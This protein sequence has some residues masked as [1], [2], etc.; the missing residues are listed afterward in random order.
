MAEHRQLVEHT[1]DPGGELPL[2]HEGDEVG[3][4]EQVPELVLDVAVVD[5]DPHRSKLEHRPEGL[6]PLDRV[7]GVDPDVVA[8]PDALGSEVVGEPVRP[9]LHL[10]IG[11]ALAVADDVLPLAEVVRRVLEEVG[12]VELH[13]SETRTRSDR[14]SDATNGAC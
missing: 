9:L 4:V 1:G 13:D 10:S 7:V 2:E 6:D 11:A 8:G 3:V 14:A 12:E 5:V